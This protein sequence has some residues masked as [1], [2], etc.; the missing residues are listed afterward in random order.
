MCSL[1]T[2]LSFSSSDIGGSSFVILIGQKLFFRFLKYFIV[3]KCSFQLLKKGRFLQ[4]VL[5]ELIKN[6]VIALKCSCIDG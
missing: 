5:N 3:S 1:T 6:I 2:G 4:G